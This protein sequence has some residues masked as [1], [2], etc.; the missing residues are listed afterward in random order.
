M[1]HEFEVLTACQSM[2]PGCVNSV[3]VVLKIKGWVKQ[4]QPAHTLQHKTM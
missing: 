3:A 1:S 4:V 2:G